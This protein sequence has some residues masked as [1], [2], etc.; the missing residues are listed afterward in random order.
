ML[1]L[2]LSMSNF[3]YLSYYSPLFKITAKKLNQGKTNIFHYPFRFIA[4]LQQCFF[5][6]LNFFS[7]AQVLTTRRGCL[8]R[9]IFRAYLLY[10]CFF[11]IM[12]LDRQKTSEIQKSSSYDSSVYS[13]HLTNSPMRLIQQVG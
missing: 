10:R 13:H 7:R 3:F 11:A 5:V 1:S 4:I 8:K 2:Q 12:Y 9:E 6:I